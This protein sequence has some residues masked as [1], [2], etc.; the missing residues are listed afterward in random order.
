MGLGILS[1]VSDV[2]AL[3]DFGC[4]LPGFLQ[5]VETKCGGSWSFAYQVSI[6][7][8][9]NVQI[10]NNNIN[11]IRGIKAGLGIFGMSL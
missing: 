1:G 11:R 8:E 10:C 9:R 6:F 4:G 5:L 3:S 7:F 2:H